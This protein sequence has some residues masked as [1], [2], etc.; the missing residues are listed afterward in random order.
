MDI[1]SSLWDVTTK[2]VEQQ[3]ALYASD[4]YDIDL[5]LL[6]A[7]STPNGRKALA[8]M[9]AVGRQ[10]GADPNLGMDKGAAWGFF[11]EGQS[12]LVWEVKQR[13]ERARLGAPKQETET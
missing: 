8:Y 12:Q 11:K 6:K 13:M 4:V 10:V 5:M 2:Q 3:N 1:D 9:E 7:F